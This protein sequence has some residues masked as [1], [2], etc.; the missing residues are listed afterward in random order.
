MKLGRPTKYNE[1]MLA[2]TRDYILNFH[3]YDDLIPSIASLS[4]H[5][6]VNRSTLYEWA[7]KYEEFS[8]ML[9]ALNKSQEKFL[10]R[11]GLSGDFNAT[12]AKLVLA[13]QGYSDKQEIEQTNK[14][15]TV[16]EEDAKSVL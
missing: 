3:K 7:D 2:K 8:N 11:G 10:L 6:E 15:F 9:E 14:N 12:I 1:E 4:L 13:K 16:G 5:L